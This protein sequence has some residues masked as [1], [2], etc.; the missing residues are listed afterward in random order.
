MEGHFCA[1]FSIISTSYLFTS[2]SNRS[3]LSQGSHLTLQ[4]LRS[5]LTARSERPNVT[6]NTNTVSYYRI[7]EAG[8]CDGWQFYTADGVRNVANN[9]SYSVSLCSHVTFHPGEA[10][11]SLQSTEHKLSSI[12]NGISHYIEQQHFFSLLAQKI[13]A[14]QAS[15]VLNNL[16]SDDAV[17]IAQV[18]LRYDKRGVE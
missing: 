14:R 12:T 1:E 5:I 16:S 8:P 11:F 15:A 18:D 3:R 17:G 2:K 7:F 6:L 13:R 4:S 9:D 10:I